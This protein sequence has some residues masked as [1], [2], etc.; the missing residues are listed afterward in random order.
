MS[1]PLSIQDQLSRWDAERM[2]AGRDGQKHMEEEE[3]QEEEEEEEELPM[4][5][6]LRLFILVV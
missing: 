3:E 6:V 1:S 4:V 5:S 2:Y